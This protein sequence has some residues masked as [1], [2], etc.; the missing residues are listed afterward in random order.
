[1]EDLRDDVFLKFSQIRRQM[2]FGCMFDSTSEKDHECLTQMGEYID[3]IHFK[4]ALQHYIDLGLFERE[5]I[6]TNGRKWYKNWLKSL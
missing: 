3:W 1:M 4:K 2:C 5:S 6:E